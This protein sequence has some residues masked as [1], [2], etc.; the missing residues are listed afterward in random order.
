[1]IASYFGNDATPT[2]NTLPHRVILVPKNNLLLGVETVGAMGE[3]EVFHDRV[4]RSLI[5]DY[6]ASM[7]AKIGINEMIQTTY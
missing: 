4:S 6:G 7:D 2:Y 1:M 5:A 3:L